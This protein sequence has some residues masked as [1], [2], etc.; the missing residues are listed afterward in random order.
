[1][2]NLAYKKAALG[3]SI[4]LTLSGFFGPMAGASPGCDEDKIQKTSTDESPIDQP[5]SNE[6][7]EPTDTQPIEL[8]DKVNRIFDKLKNA[9]DVKYYSFTALRGQQ[10]MINHVRQ[11]TENSYW[12]IEYNLGEKWQLAP[13]FDSLI[14][15]SLIAG[16]KVKLRISHPT[17]SPFQPNRFYHIDFGSAPYAH[18]IRIE[19]R[20]PKTG[21]YFST[22]TFR[23]QITWSTNIRDSTDHFLEGATVDFILQPDDQ[24]P[25]NT[26]KSQR[27]TTTGGI[28][29][30]IDFQSCTGRHSTNPFTGVYDNV[31]WW[32]A[33]YN[34]GHWYVTIR[35]NPNTGISPVPITQVCTIGITG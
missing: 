33:G 19:T 2:K 25:S 3:T 22:T 14:T 31:T 28:V 32:R 23:D 1:M 21:T 20:G 15:S 12:K 18:N 17:S 24:N 26:L 29:Q 10:V 30:Y 8:P 16:Q 11:G 5:P 6:L 35:G 34:T 4:I 27:I 13:T 9:T 7:A